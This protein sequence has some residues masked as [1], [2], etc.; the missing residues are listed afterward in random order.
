MQYWEVPASE[1][2][3]VKG[4]WVHGPAEEFFYALLK[5]FSYLPIIAEDLGMITPDV[6]EFI[7]R[8]EFPGMQVLL[9]GF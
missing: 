1:E 6:R 5:R 9:F 7:R 8:F 4:K 3:A 2:T